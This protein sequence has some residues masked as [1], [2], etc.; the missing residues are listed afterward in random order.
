MLIWIIDMFMEKILFIANMFS[1][2]DLEVILNNSLLTVNCRITP[3]LLMSE[4]NVQLYRF[5]D[6]VNAIAKHL[7]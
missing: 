2:I 3:S 6:K 5:C 7:L 1:I 4:I